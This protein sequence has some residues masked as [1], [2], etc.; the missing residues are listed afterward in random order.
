MALLKPGKVGII[1][2][3]MVCLEHVFKQSVKFLQIYYYIF[4]P[5][6]VSNY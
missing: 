2:A 5:V 3:T 1:L 4:I 6:V